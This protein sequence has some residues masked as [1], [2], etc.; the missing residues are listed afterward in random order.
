[1]REGRG[2]EARV[3]GPDKTAR[4]GG[5][6][7]EASTR[8]EPVAGDRDRQP[9]RSAGPSRGA[10]ADPFFFRPYEPSADSAE[11]APQESPEGHVSGSR[12]PA[13]KVA[14]LLGGKPDAQ[15]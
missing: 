1:P 2:R 8:R 4:E 6:R 13:R 3:A 10:K 11:P 15:H 5:A 9:R 7:R 12:R 14:A